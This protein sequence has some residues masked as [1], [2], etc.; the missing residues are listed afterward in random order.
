MSSLALQDIF[1]MVLPGDV[2]KPGEL[3]SF[4][5][6]FP[7]RGSTCC[8][9][10]S[11]FLCGVGNA[12]ESPEAFEMYSNASVCVCYQNPALAFTEDEYCEYVKFYHSGY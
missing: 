7:L 1:V 8:L 9:T 2:A 6:C 11:F 12:E 5:S 4:H 10:Y 3:L